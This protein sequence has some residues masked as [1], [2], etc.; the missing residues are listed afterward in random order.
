[1]EQKDLSSK[2]FKSLADS[3]SEQYREAK[4]KRETNNLLAVESQ[5]RHTMGFV[6]MDGEYAIRNT[7]KELKHLLSPGPKG[8]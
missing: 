3:N 4:S 6:V 7:G 5:L 2:Q 1:M 8:R